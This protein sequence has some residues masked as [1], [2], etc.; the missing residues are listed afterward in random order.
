MH[1]LYYCI[2]VPRYLL[3]YDIVRYR[4]L[5]CCN[6]A[7]HRLIFYSI[8]SLFIG[9][10]RSWD[11]NYLDLFFDISPLIIFW[12][13]WSPSLL[14]YL[15]LLF[16]A[17][18]ILLLRTIIMTIGDGIF[19]RGCFLFTTST[20]VRTCIWILVV[21]IVVFFSH[22]CFHA[23]LD[24]RWY[25]FLRS[26]VR[27]MESTVGAHGSAARVPIGAPRLPLS[28]E[29]G[30]FFSCSFR[31]SSSSSSSGSFLASSS[32]FDNNDEN[33]DSPR[34]DPP[35]SRS[36]AGLPLGFLRSSLGICLLHFFTRDSELWLDTR[37]RIDF[38]SAGKKKFYALRWHFGWSL[39]FEDDREL[40]WCCWCPTSSRIRT[41]LPN[42]R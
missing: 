31:T 16:L 35:S 7:I 18:R 9:W 1:L 36:F 34:P 4:L 12:F 23:F 32:W 5:L 38:G 41:D 29:R 42:S 11:I 33:E 15:L 26:V 6:H 40:C 3:L 10:Q 39:G 20:T 24:G 13:P 30:N 2:M 27:C 37:F 21:P 22:G 17:T 19:G 28:E 25:E 14:F 8:R